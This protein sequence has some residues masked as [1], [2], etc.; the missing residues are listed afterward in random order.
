MEFAALDINFT[1]IVIALLFMALDILTGFAQAAY[2][3]DISSK[4][5]KRGLWH[6]TGFILVIVLAGLCEYSINYIDL[7]FTL[8]LIEV[9]CGFIIA[10]EIV[11]IIE[12]IIKITPELANGK[13][14]ALF[15][16]DKIKELIL[17]DEQ[18]ED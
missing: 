10:T 11:S 16:T 4:V 15:R 8:P 17:T 12:N 18:S 14:L 6:K 13:F 2:N 1:I 5:M 3:H 7:G 9:V